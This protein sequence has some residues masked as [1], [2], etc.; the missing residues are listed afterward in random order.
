MKPTKGRLTGE[1]HMFI[2]CYLHN[3][4]A[5]SP[6]RVL[7]VILAKKGTLRQVARCLRKFLGKLEAFQ[8]LKKFSEEVGLDFGESDLRQGSRD[9]KNLLGGHGEGIGGRRRCRR[10]QKGN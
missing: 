7:F 8:V 4:D 10:V 5:A 6:V 2:L 3:L 9:P 1:K